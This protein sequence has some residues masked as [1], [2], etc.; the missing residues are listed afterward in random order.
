MSI[1]ARVK[2]V[3]DRVARAEQSSGRKAGSVRLVAVCKKISAD[4]VREAYHEGLRDFAENYV[5]E[6]LLK[7]AA[8]NDLDIHWHMIGHLQTNKVKS[9]SNR[10]SLIQSVDSEKLLEEI[11]K[12]SEKTQ[13]ILVEV[14][15]GDEDTKSGLSAHE[16]KALLQ[17]VQLQKRVVARGLMF[18]PPMDLSVIEQAQYF[19]RAREL[20]E[21]MLREIS[22]PHN[23]DDLS[24]GT[25]HDFEVAI[26]EGATIVRLGTAIF[27]PRS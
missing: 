19:E 6:A 26:Q 18:M 10:F 24:M 17:K 25:S 11:E 7:M 14:N 13:E 22:A 27:G 3:Q 12:R 5:Q 1:G 16:L 15:L 2:E 9:I 8:L 23:L 4:L 21:R 20:R